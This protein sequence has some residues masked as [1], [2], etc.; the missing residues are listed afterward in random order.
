MAITYTNMNSNALYTV[1]LTGTVQSSTSM[2]VT[3]LA[4]CVRDAAGN[5]LDFPSVNNGAAVT[6]NSTPRTLTNTGTFPAGTYKW[7]ICY[8]ANGSWQ[9][10]S[11]FPHTFTVGATAAT[12]PSTGTGTT[13]G[14]TGTGGSTTT[15]PATTTPPVTATTPSGVNMP[16][17]N[18][19]RNG[20]TWVPVFNE[21][22]DTTA[23][24][25]Q[26]RNTYVN[27]FHL[28][29]EGEGGKY[30][31]D[32]TVTAQNS[33][34]D[35]YF[36]HINGADA[37]FAGRFLNPN[38]EWAF[39][40]GRFDIRYRVT[41]SPEGY[42][43]AFMLWPQSE[44]WGEGEIDY[45]EGEL[46]S[47]QG[48]NQHAL[49]SNP[50]SKTLMAGNVANWSDWHTASIE[51]VPGVSMRYYMDD[52]LVGTEINPSN[53][54]TTEHAWIIQAA[55]NNESVDGAPDSSSGHLQIDW[56]VAYK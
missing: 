21:D 36:H 35:V 46:T 49:G 2:S 51:W 4:I 40:G 41:G 23:A 34:M 50:G 44:I 16:T 20:K 31:G 29:N 47:S 54:P 39:K 12:T 37:G 52:K 26:F 7:G 55:A 3:Y 15:P 18:V 27:R 32:Q 33:L 19:T 30:F 45:P 42:G 24:L 9:G 8:F 56:A 48:L 1:N 53:V 10:E 6:L 43:A 11:D 25:G 13:G 17:G 38:G 22:F 5:N 28:N 14:S